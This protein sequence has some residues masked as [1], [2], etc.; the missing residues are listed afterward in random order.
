MKIIGIIRSAE[1][2]PNMGEADAAI[3]EAVATRLEADGHM[4]TRLTDEQFLNAFPDDNPTY[5]PAIEE[6]VEQADRIFTMS[7][8]NN[9]C[10]M[11][12]VVER[13]DKTPCI[14][15][16][17]GVSACANRH[18]IYAALKEAGVAQPPTWF[19][20]LYKERWPNDPEDAY[21]LSQRLPYP[22]WIKRGD[23]HSQV[24]EDVVLVTDVAQ[25]HEALEDFIR[26]GCEE[27][28]LC[29]HLEGDLVKFYGV[30][31][32]N[33]FDWDYADPAH[34]KFGLEIH[35]GP[36]NHYAFDAQTLQER[37]QFV[38][39]KA[40]VPV[41]GGDAIVQADGLWYIVDFNDWPSFSRCRDKAADAIIEIIVK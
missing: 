11:L 40:G 2:S 17:R 1:F 36:S 29:Q 35:N 33:F 24:K 34:S 6:L 30:A 16:G 41:Y 5:D 37:C 9:T 28:A 31:G 13:F 3:F 10:Y 22:L 39:S 4:V 32:T 18:Q 23:G 26:R 27:V 8:N 15:S 20:S 14:N 38:A 21:S 19:G 25:A 12:D 7:R